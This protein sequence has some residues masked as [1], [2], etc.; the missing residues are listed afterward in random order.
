MKKIK[1][2]ITIVLTSIF[3]AGI[4]ENCTKEKAAPSP[5]IIVSVT[6][7]AGV[8]LNSA[9]QATNIPLNAFVIVAFDQPVDTTQA[10]LSS[11]SLS[12]NGAVVPS[13]ITVDGS[14]VTIKSKTNLTTGTVETVSVT[15]ELKGTN[16]AGTT[17]ADITF[18]T[19]GHTYVAPP[20]ASNQ[21]SY[22]SFSGNMN[23][24][25]GTHTPAA[26]AIKDLTFTTDRFGFAGLTGDFNGSTSLVEIPNGDQYL[27][28]NSFTF[29]FWVKANS[30]KNGQ[31]VLGLG[32][33]YGFYMELAADWTWLRF[34]N[35]F[36]GAGNVT[37]TEDNFFYGNGVTGSN[38]GWQGWTFQSTVAGGVG[39]TYF[40]DKWAHVVS[41]YDAAT[42]LAT[43]Y[44]NGEKVKQQDF[45]LWSENNLERTITGVKFAGNLTGGGNA[46]AL[47][48][49]QGSQNRIITDT[50]AD[51]ANL[52]SEHF[53]GQM[54]DIR[55]FKVALTATEVSTLYSAEKP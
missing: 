11:I 39:A 43:I 34:T 48:F 52:Y 29:S 14:T 45:N 42:K 5:L 25:V 20:Q 49:I 40:Q 7:D 12:A 41:T 21:L 50:W 9:T 6:T 31:F 28:N 16:G 36:T 35:Q 33:W 18:K 10:N 23:D 51:P 30:T 37:S 3:V 24:E 4:L 54:D 2:P 47:G 19:L 53:Q 44:I 27:T 15:S 32:A 26:A 8:D 46:L 1:L 13:K 22:F 17:A 38:G 55:I